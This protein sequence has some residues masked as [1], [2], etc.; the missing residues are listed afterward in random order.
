MISQLT[1]SGAELIDLSYI[2]NQVDKRQNVCHQL[3]SSSPSTSIPSSRLPEIPLPI[4]DGDFHKWPTFRDQFRANID[5]RSIPKADK[6]YY[7]VGCLRGVASDAIRGIPMSE[8]NYDL[9]WSTLEHRF[10]RPRLVAMSLIDKLFQLPVSTHESLTGLNTFVSK[11]SEGLSLLKSLNIPDLGSFVLFSMAFRCLP[12]ATRELFETTVTS[13]GDY[14][15]IDALL[16]CIQ[17]RVSTLEIIGDSKPGT[18]SSQSKSYRPSNRKGDR[19]SQSSYPHAASLLTTKSEKSCPCCKASH[20]LDSCSQFVSWATEERSKWMRDHSLCFNCFSDSHWSNK[21]R[22]KPSCK[23]CSRNHHTLLHMGGRNTKEKVPEP[24][25]KS[26][27]CTSQPMSAASTSCSVMLGTAL[28]HVRDRSGTWQT[29]R[30]LV[31]CASQIS[32]VTVSCADRLGLKRSSWTASVTGLAGHPV[33]SVMGRIDCIVQPRFAPEPSLAIQ[34]WVLPSITG[35]MPHKTLDSA[36]KDKFSNLALA[37]PSFHVASSVDMLLGADIYA[38]IMNGHKIEIDSSLPSAFNS[39]FG[40]I[41]IGPVPYTN[42]E[43]L[44]ALPVSLTISIEDQMNKFWDI[45]EPEAAPDAFTDEGKCES[46]FRNECVRLPSGRFS[47]PL[48][49]R[50]PVSPTT[51]AGSRSMALKRFESLERKL[52]SNPHLHTLYKNFMSDYLALGHMSVAS[53]PGHYFVPHHAVYKADDGDAKI[54]VVFD[55]SARCSAGPS[56]NSCLLPGPKLQQDLIDVLTRFRIYPHAFTADICKMYRQIQV[57]PEYRKY[58]HILWRSSPHDQL[59]EYQLNTVTYG[60][61]CAPFLAIRV[62]QSIA[63]TDCVDADHVRDALLYQ[64]YVDDICVGADSVEEALEF[65]SSLQRILAKSGLELKK[66]SSNT[67]KILSSVPAADRVST[68]LP[69]HDSEDGGTKVLGLQWNP[70]DD[71]FS[72]ALRF[73]PSPIFTKRGVLSM[74]AR[75]FDPLGLFGPTIFL[76]KCIMQRTWQLGL[77]WDEPLPPEIHAD[78]SSFLSD[79]PSLSMIRVSRHF[80][81]FGQS[82]CY[83]LGFCDAS[84]LGYAAVVY[85]LSADS[86]SAQ[87]AVL[88]GSKT[89]LAPMKPLTIPR[90]ELNAALL[91]A[92]WLG[93]IKRILDPHLKIIGTYCWTDSMIVLSWL[94]VPHTSFKVYVSNRIHQIRTIVPDCKWS[95]IESTNNPADCASRGVMPSELTKLSLYW[96]GP[97]I[98]R[99]NPSTW[100]N[101]VTPMP[102]CTLPEVLPV[103]LT[104]RIDPPDCTEEWFNRFSSYDRMIRVTTI[105]HRFIN[106]RCPRCVLEPLS[107][108]CLSLIEVDCATRSIIRES[109]RIHFSELLR[110]LSTGTRVS[111]KP[112][113]RLAP[114]VDDVG[115][116]RVGGRLRHSTL[117]YECKHPMLIAKRSHLALLICRRWHRLTCHSG[118]RVMISL[119]L[120]QYWII[121]IRSVVHEVVT[122]CSVCV[123]LAAKPPQPLMADL[124]AARVQQVRPFA[125]VG[126]DYAGP[127]QMRELKL[128]KSRSYKVYIA[129]FVCFSIKAV[130]LEVVSDLS[131]DA[132]LAAFDRFVGRRGLPSDVYSD[133]GTNFIGADKQLQTLINSPQGQ[134]AITTNSRPHCKWHF[135]PPSAP[136]FGGLWEAAVRSTKRLLVRTMSTH[137]FTYEEFTTVLIRIE[138]VLNSRPL[139]PASTDP[140][141]LECLT[142]GHFLI[143][144]PLLAVPPRSNPDANRNLTNRWKLLDQCH[145]AF[146]KRWSSE[147]LTTLQQRVKWTDR[148]PN[149]KVNDMV[150]VVDN[151]A[152]PLLWR[153]GRIIELVPGSDGTV[154]VASVLTHHG[155]ITRPVVKLVVLPTD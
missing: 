74:V 11:F 54:R 1:P 76:A 122:K 147:Y 65:Q 19:S 95:H 126:V 8:D 141:D 28:V 86:S 111:S 96:Q 118:P 27:L 121:A 151:Q 4:Y 131:T 6:M 36:I 116:I 132:F 25:A 143:G 129:V 106:R 57:L 144:Q 50:V 102:L 3:G 58:Q 101:L 138:A 89:K 23:Q 44:H 46:I 114:F 112:L 69:F 90:L 149:L 18:A 33:S 150:V 61:T 24:Q 155:R 34:A 7:L 98:L 123:R 53:T 140:H 29:M 83:L 59:V 78:W 115:I 9:A 125:R 55:A 38:T 152:P 79:L 40:W 94:T 43:P 60:V 117:S 108:K 91:L 2:K 97:A 81:T 146:W 67:H 64:T 21:C 88:V 84:Q 10:N 68:P 47:V 105:L 110:E 15:T 99:A 85:V 109:Q 100:I 13:Q 148:V 37:D 72:C 92:R 22:S 145:Q 80:S 142:P 107:T 135:N 39:I 93:R 5:S 56:L 73:K 113:A 51:F 130:H 35:D 12:I 45:E 124:P 104:T 31:D 52:L 20:S 17:S 120:R 16:A 30:A 139:T 70:N 42:V 71:F 82:S 49:F 75:I 134:L 128:R 41:L 153:L 77:A 26:S 103:S 63:E 127:L 62:L 87:P 48:P 14:P 66:W 136:H 32:A 119:I 137:V 154:R 133:C